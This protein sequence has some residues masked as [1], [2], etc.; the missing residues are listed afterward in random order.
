[1]SFLQ[2]NTPLLCCKHQTQCG[3]C[4]E[5]WRNLKIWENVKGDYYVRHERLLHFIICRRITK[6]HYKWVP[7]ILWWRPGEI[8]GPDFCTVADHSYSRFWCCCKL[9]QLLPI[10]FQID[11]QS[12]SDDKYSVDSFPWAPFAVNMLHWVQSRGFSSINEEIKSS[13]SEKHH[14]IFWMHVLWG[15]IAR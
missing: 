11:H 5:I 14:P 15:L 12:V 6:E 4:F 3:F 13:N 1:M 2:G 7:C 9:S 8:N 10:Q